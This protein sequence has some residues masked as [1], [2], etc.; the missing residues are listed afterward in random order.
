MPN[1]RY[2][3]FQE[4]SDDANCELVGEFEI[5]STRRGFASLSIERHEYET[6]I[7]G[8]QVF[9]GDEHADGHDRAAFLQ[10]LIGGQP[11]NSATMRLCGW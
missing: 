2:A 7:A 1:T 9:D 6:I 5:Q 4:R 11:I 10:K 8:V 3:V